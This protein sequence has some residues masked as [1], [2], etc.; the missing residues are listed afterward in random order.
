MLAGYDAAMRGRTTIL[1]TP[2][3][4]VAAAADRVLVLGNAGI[5]EQ[6]AADELGHGT[7]RSPRCSRRPDPPCICATA[8]VAACASRSS[9]AASRGAPACRWHRAGHRDSGDGS[10]DDD[11]V[12]RLVWDGGRRRFVKAPDA[13]II[14]I[15]VFW[16][17]L[18]TDALS[19]DRGIDEA[20][21]ARPS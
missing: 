18:A 2:H 4:A 5:V 20:C 19:L 11:F 21:A 7:V 13:A 6:G 8:P 12:D 17:S 1:I 16:R 14:A 15:K 3:A 9:I 10:L